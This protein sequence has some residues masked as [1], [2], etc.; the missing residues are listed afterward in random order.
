MLMVAK[1]LIES[2]ITDWRIHFM[3]IDL[4]LTGKRSR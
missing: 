1:V 4:L 2:E 3:I